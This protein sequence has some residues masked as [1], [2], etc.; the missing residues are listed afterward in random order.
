M[1]GIRVATF[2]HWALAL[3]MTSALWRMCP[4]ANASVR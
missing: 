3:S 1:T 4:E 2:A